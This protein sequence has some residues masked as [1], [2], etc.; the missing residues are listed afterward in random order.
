MPAARVL[1]GV[2]AAHEITS[3]DLFLARVSSTFHGRDIF[4]PVAAHLAS[5]LPLERVGPAV[6]PAT[7]VDLMLP[8]G[9]VREG[10]LETAVLLI[11]SFGNA[12]LAGQ[13]DDLVRSTGGALIPGRRFRVTGA[14][15]PAGGVDVPW[16]SAFG[17]VAAGEPLLYEDADYGGLGIAVNQAS[18]A[19]RFG[20][21]SD[22]PLRIEAI[23]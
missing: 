10:V 13:P 4:S 22:T 9:R 1:G 15:I 14:S 5:G 21:G 20:L 18:A 11:D 17:E 7:L 19:E 2:A 16:Q 8:E 12:R 23:A 6:D 3:T